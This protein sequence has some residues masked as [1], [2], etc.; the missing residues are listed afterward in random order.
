MKGRIIM[1]KIIFNNKI[2]KQLLN[3]VKMIFQYKILISQQKAGTV[4]QQDRNGRLLKK[5]LKII[6]YSRKLK[7]RFLIILKLHQIYRKKSLNIQMKLSWQI[8]IKKMVTSTMKKLY[9]KLL[10][11]GNFN[12]ATKA[13]TMRNYKISNILKKMI[14]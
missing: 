4:V 8:K 2:L 11:I 5:K 13:M 14:L 9:S 10:L 6:F 1:V 7:I 12:L 3:K